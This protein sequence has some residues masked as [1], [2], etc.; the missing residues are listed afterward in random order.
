MIGV[1]RVLWLDQNAWIDLARGAWD[2]TAFPQAHAALTTV[3]EAVKARQ[4][5]VPLTFANVYETA[6][7]NDPVRREHLAGVQSAIS[8]GLVFRNRRYLFERSLIQYLATRFSLPVPPLEDRWFMSDLW[9]ESAA[10][11]APESY[12]F[13]ISDAV[14]EHIRSNPS[15]ALFHYLTEGDEKVCIEGVRQYSAGSNEL[16]AQI[17]ARRRVVADES[18]A[19]R[20][21]AYGARLTID[22]FDFICRVANRLGLQWDKPSDLGSSLV[23]ALAVDIPVLN[24]ERELVVRLESQSRLIGENDLRDMASFIVVLPFADVVVAEKTLVNISRQG[25]LGVRYQTRLLTSVFDLT[26][27]M[28]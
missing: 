24:I 27:D 23:R 7:I 17:E 6:K 26:P 15:F 19:V 10:E 11:Y 5:L 28:L 21:R 9:F 4:L 16:I 1:K 20:K 25:R 14:L 3:I 22:E 18:L 8:S 2:R 12:G 13:Q